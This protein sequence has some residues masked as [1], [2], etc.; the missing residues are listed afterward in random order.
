MNVQSNRRDLYFKNVVGDKDDN[1]EML[2]LDKLK[3]LGLTE[4]AN[5]RY[6]GE[7]INGNGKTIRIG[8]PE[9]QIDG[10]IIPGIRSYRDLIKHHYHNVVMVKK[11]GRC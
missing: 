4:T 2:D 1:S 6:I 3:A 8:L 11:R 5:V 7:K 9:F 10:K